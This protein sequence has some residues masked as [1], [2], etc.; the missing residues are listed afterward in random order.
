MALSG[1]TP[2]EVASAPF[3]EGEKPIDRAAAFLVSNE[4]ILGSDAIYPLVYLRRRFGA[5]WAQGA[6]DRLAVKSRE[7]EY[8]ETLYPFLR[9]LDPTARYSFDPAAPPPVFAAA[10]TAWN[11]VRALH[12]SEVPLT[13]DFIKSVDEQALAWDRGAAIGA[14]AIGWAADQGC[15]DNF[16]LKAIDDRLKEK[17]LDYVRSHD[18]TDVGYVEAVATLLYR[19]QRS[20]V[21]PAWI[22]KIESIQAPEGSW[23][24]TGAAT[25]RSTSESL[26]ALIQFANPDAPRVSWVPLG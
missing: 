15:L 23:N 19:G 2:E 22:S 3:I 4:A 24:L 9:L 6:M 17:M 14:R 11:L 25:D 21:D 26:L 5:E 13:S 8:K 16:D 18:A 1:C 12:C 7:P 20:S 10:P